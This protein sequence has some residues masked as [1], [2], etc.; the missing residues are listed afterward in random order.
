[1]LKAVAYCRA[2]NN[3]TILNYLKLGVNNDLKRI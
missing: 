2:Y 1:M 3:C